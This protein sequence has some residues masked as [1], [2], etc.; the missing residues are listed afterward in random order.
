MIQRAMWGVSL[1]TVRHL[2]VINFLSWELGSSIW[3]W[4][5]RLT[6]CKSPLHSDIHSSPDLHWIKQA[7]STCADSRRNRDAFAEKG[8]FSPF[9]RVGL[10]QPQGVYLDLGHLDVRKWRLGSYITTRPKPCLLI[11]TCLPWLGLGS[12]LVYCR[13]SQQREK[14]FL[15]L[16]NCTFS[17]LSPSY[18]ETD[19]LDRAWEMSL[20]SCLPSCFFK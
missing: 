14:G 4:T 1:H 20:F 11:P 7:G 9:I 15:H 2:P 18:A 13:R 10:H 6:K 17:L 16:L 3:H 8:R 12:Q 19:K 5:L